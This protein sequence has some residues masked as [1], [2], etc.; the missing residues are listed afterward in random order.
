MPKKKN[1]EEELEKV[2]GELS[3]LRR[4]FSETEAERQNLYSE[5]R[6]LRAENKKLSDQSKSYSGSTKAAQKEREEW[7]DRCHRAERILENV[8]VSMRLLS[9]TVERL[10]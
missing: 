10:A 2:K 1:P 3:E 4:V 5:A 6:H 8:S 7:K 9:E